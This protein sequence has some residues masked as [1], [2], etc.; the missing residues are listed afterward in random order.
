[1]NGFG[2]DV[3]P[4]LALSRETWGEEQLWDAVKDLPHGCVR[5]E[6][7]APQR[8]T[9]PFGFERPAL[10]THVMYAAQAGDVARLRWLLARGARL[11]L[12]DWVGR[13]ALFWASQ[14]GHVEVVRELLARGAAVDAADNGG[15]APLFIA[16]QNGHLEVVRALMEEGAS[17][18]APDSFFL[19]T[20]KTFN[21]GLTPLYVASERGHLEI[22]R[23]LL[24]GG[25]EVDA[26]MINTLTPL[27]A[28]CKRRHL[29]VLQLLL[30]EGASIDGLGEPNDTP[31]RAAC[32]DGAVEIVREL[33]VRG[34]KVNPDN[35]EESPLV[36]ATLPGASDAIVGV[37]LG[38]GATLAAASYHAYSPLYYIHC[39]G[40]PH[41][42]VT[43]IVKDLLA[44]GGGCATEVLELALNTAATNG[45][46]DSARLLR[47]A[48]AAQ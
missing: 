3:E 25:A 18:N 24:E 45:Y 16:S 37:L 5:R 46:P 34:A 10:R 22:V 42:L 12:K 28:A 31:L 30:D 7:P 17:V 33:L 23:E 1:M 38:A 4:F 44:R 13:T 21:G 15:T 2:Q 43:K 48:L 14:E 29:A 32:Q 20:P 11:E 8:A 19:W 36:A 41:L 40:A 47:A 6:G 35:W 27:L 39:Y 26:L 9:E